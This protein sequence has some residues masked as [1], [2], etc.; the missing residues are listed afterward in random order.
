MKF[1]SMFASSIPLETAINVNIDDWD[2]GLE[3]W[4]MSLC[5]CCEGV[6]AFPEAVYK[7]DEDVEFL[8][9]NC[10][11][12]LHTNGDV[13]I[14][15]TCARACVTSFCHATKGYWQ[16]LDCDKDDIPDFNRGIWDK[17]NWLKKAYKQGHF[18][19]LS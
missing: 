11:F 18:F 12:D 9:R 8:C 19:T 14:C 2:Q 6:V 16:C 1:D 10:L 4:D 7:S 3:L 15:P 5:P 13:E 17:W